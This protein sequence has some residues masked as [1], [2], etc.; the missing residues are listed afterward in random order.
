MSTV[1]IRNG[2]QLCAECDAADC[3]RDDRRNE[4]IEYGSDQP[5]GCC[6]KPRIA[7]FFPCRRVKTLF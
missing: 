3:H 1:V 5:C 2:V 6:E 7:T 4:E